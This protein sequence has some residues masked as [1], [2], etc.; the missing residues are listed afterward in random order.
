MTLGW[1]RDN[2]TSFSKEILN[3]IAFCLK[4]GG[5][6][7]TGVM[8]QWLGLLVALA[9]DWVWSLAPLGSPQLCVMPNARGS[10]AS[11]DLCGHVCVAQE[12]M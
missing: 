3:E 2:L 1:E 8:V 9:K 12:H 6:E 5:R 7:A 11:S 10:D 4:T